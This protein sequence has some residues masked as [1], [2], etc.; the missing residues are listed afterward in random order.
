M[1]RF[2]GD[3]IV[4]KNGE[5][6]FKAASEHCSARCTLRVARTTVDVV[7]AFSRRATLQNRATVD[8]KREEEGPAE[9]PARPTLG[10]S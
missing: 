5:F 1:Y 9:A 2:V 7:Q 4:E 3:K 8:E 6:V 10:E